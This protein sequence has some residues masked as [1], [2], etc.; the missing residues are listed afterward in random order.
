MFQRCAET[1]LEISIS[2]YIYIIYIYIKIFTLFRAVLGSKPHQPLIHV[3]KVLMLSKCGVFLSKTT[4]HQ[5]KF[6]DTVDNALLGSN[7]NFIHG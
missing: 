6:F 5:K 1:T 7:R 4:W 2:I 3:P